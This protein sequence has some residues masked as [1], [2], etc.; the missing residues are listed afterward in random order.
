MAKYTYAITDFPND[1]VSN[2][3]LKFEIEQSSI[4]KSLE[5]ITTTSSVCDIVFKDDLT[6][7]EETTLNGVVSSHS[8]SYDEADAPVMPDGRPIV[9]ADTRPL[10][11]QT[12]FTSRGDSATNIGDGGEMKWDFSDST[13]NI[14]TGPEV[15]EGFKAKEFLLTFLCPVYIKDGAI[16][17]F[18]APW[19]QKVFMQI[20]VPNGGYYPNPKGMIPAAALG[21]PGDEMY[22]QASGNTLYQTYVNNHYI[23]GDCP[24]GDELNA[25]G[26]AVNPIPPGWYLR[27]LIMTP[28]DDVVSK[29]YASIELYR[30][31]NTLLPGQTV[32]DLH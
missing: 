25:E 19:G 30:C 28:E 7:G 18:D 27:G 23:H 5:S 3:G 26:C 32:E 16:Y 22:A 13:S 1:K 10:D 29:G 24:M 11:T 20:V 21:L 8:G 12:F 9:R 31:H 2:A 15:P 14:Y 4:T 17:F 6:S